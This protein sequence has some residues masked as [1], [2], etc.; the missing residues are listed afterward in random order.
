MQIL[1]PIGLGDLLDRITIL[2]LKQE[3]ITDPHKIANINRELALL[4]NI[5]Q[6]V[7]AQYQLPNFDTET[8]ELLAVNRELWHIEE[9]KRQCERESCFDEDFVRAARAVYLQNDRRAE[10][11]RRINSLSGSAVV[12]EKSHTL[13]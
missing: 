9:F 8:A 2:Q 7:Q 13:V 1:A 6:D 3:Y 11:K 10:I 4:T 12:E 5:M